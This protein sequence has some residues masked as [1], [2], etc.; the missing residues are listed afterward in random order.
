MEKTLSFAD[1]ARTLKKAD[2][3]NAAY[4][5]LPQN[6]VYLG[7]DLVLVVSLNDWKVD[8]HLCQFVRNASGELVPSENE[9]ILSPFLWVSLCNSMNNP[10]FIDLPTTF[11]SFSLVENELFLAAIENRYVSMQRCGLQ[12]NY[13]RYFIPG[14]LTMED[15]QWRRLKYTS[16]LISDILTEYLIKHELKSWIL[17]EAENHPYQTVIN[18]S[19]A[20]KALKTSLCGLMKT[21]LDRT[22]NTDFYL[23]L[24]KLD[25]KQIAYEFV[26]ENKS[27]LRFIGEELFDVTDFVRQLFP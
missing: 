1:T 6:C 13:E 20:E 5:K 7:K 22:M 14:T 26:Q 21:H 24:T 4:T 19:G 23:A 10:S 17:K 9:I 2:I 27:L 11:E 12:N 18:K 15:H 25:L 3:Y 8:V 16:K